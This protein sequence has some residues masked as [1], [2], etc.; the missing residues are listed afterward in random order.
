[1]RFED[2]GKDRNGETSEEVGLLNGV[3]QV[4]ILNDGLVLTLDLRASRKAGVNSLRDIRRVTGTAGRPYRGLTKPLA[5][6][7]RSYTGLRAP[8]RRAGVPGAHKWPKV[9]R[10]K[11]R[12]LQ[13]ADARWSSILC[14]SGSK[15]RF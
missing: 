5:E 3:N 4:V 15:F 9:R 13:M 12:E 6:A 8:E 1:V 7:P 10:R 2:T 11:Q 14:K